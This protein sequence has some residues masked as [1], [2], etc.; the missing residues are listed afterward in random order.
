[1]QSGQVSAPEKAQLFAIS[2]VY[3]TSGRTHRPAVKSLAKSAP[4]SDV[5]KYQE[6]VGIVAQGREQLRSRREDQDAEEGE[7]SEAL[8]NAG[9]VRRPLITVAITASVSI[10]EL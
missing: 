6:A 1:M 4:Q 10:A 3:A 8:N 9:A 7:Q 2:Q 5:R